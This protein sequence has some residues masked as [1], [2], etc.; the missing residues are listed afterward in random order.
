MGAVQRE[1]EAWRE[2]SWTTPGSEIAVLT[3]FP[4]RG[5]GQGLLHGPGMCFPEQRGVIVN[6]WHKQSLILLNEEVKKKKK[7][8]NNLGYFYFK[9]HSLR[10]LNNNKKKS[11]ISLVSMISGNRHL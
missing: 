9:I 4:H 3:G 1:C 11:H 7:T 6:K 5:A 8:C 10:S 2:E